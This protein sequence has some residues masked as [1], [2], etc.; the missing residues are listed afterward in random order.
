[1]IARGEEHDREADR[2]REQRAEKRD[3]EGLDRAAES[4]VQRAGR[5]VGRKELADIPQNLPAALAAEQLAQ[6]NIRA[7]VA[8]DE[9]RDNTGGDE[10]VGERGAA[11]PLV[12]RPRHRRGLFARL[13]SHKNARTLLLRMSTAATMMKRMMRIVNTSLKLNMRIE[14]SIC[15]PSPPAPTR[16]ST[17]EARTAHSQR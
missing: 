15:C 11:A 6:A 16:P 1:E 10:P 5:E 9:Q 4:L 17:A 2:E 8:P 7:V 14:I 12:P 13:V 3:R